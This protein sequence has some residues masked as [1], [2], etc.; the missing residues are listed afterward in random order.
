MS[1]DG[2]HLLGE[3]QITGIEKAEQGVPKIDVT[4]EV[5]TNGLLTV[6]ARDRVTGSEANVSLQ[7][8][9]G[10]LTPEEIE[11][12]CAEAEAMREEDEMLQKQREIDGYMD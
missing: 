6:T 1:T 10:R 9:R 3:F 8:D 11:R 7:H 2:N 12:M 5:N 4:F